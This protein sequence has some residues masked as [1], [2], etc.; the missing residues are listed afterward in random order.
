MIYLLLL[1]WITP[2]LPVHSNPS[3]IC[4]SSEEEQLFKYINEY[5]ATK[6]LAEI[7]FSAALTRVAQAH[8][9]DLED[10]YTSP[11]GKCNPHSWSS[12]GDWSSCCYTNDHKAASCMWDKP[13]EISG[14][15]SPGYE[16]AYFASNGAKAREGLDGWI[17]SPSHHPLIINTNTWSTVTWN[18]MG[19]GIYGKYAVVWFGELSDD[20]SYKRCD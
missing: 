8:V 14:Y 19:I 3:D 17:R 18:A 20:S 16:I 10:N 1:I 12:E 13:N 7:P 9:R 5:R 2:S 11:D 6:G 4:I 15:K